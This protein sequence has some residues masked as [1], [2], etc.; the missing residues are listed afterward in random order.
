VIFDEKNCE[1]DV[2]KYPSGPLYND[3]FGIIEDIRSTIPPMNTSTSLS[4]SIP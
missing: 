3:P 2:L 4:T 1:L